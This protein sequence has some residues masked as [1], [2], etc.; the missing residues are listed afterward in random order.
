MITVRK[1]FYTQTGIEKEEYV[2][3]LSR[4]GCPLAERQL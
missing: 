2:M 4:E 1:I 3:T